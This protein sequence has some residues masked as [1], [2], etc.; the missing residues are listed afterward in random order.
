MRN[1][2][3]IKTF[4][5]DERPIHQH[6]LKKQM[7]KRE[8]RFKTSDP[9]RSLVERLLNNHHNKNIHKHY[10]RYIMCVFCISK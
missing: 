3:A 5:F 10:N 6:K 2:Y 7:K 8:N 4:A 9:L 1:E